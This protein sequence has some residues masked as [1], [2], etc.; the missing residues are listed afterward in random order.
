MLSQ[1]QWQFLQYV[2]EK[3]NNQQ[4]K[5]WKRFLKQLLSQK[6]NTEMDF[7][8]KN[9]EFTIA[10]DRACARIEQEE[11]YALWC[12]KMQNQ[13]NRCMSIEKEEVLNQIE[14]Q[15][16]AGRM[17]D[18][19]DT[20]AYRKETAENTSTESSANG[21]EEISK[22]PIEVKE[23]ILDR[24]E[25][26]TA[27][28]SIDNRHMLAHWIITTLKN[29]LRIEKNI[30]SSKWA[31]RVLPAAEGIG[32]VNLIKNIAKNTTYL[33][34]GEIIVSADNKKI[35]NGIASKRLREIQHDQE[36]GATIEGIKDVI[37]RAKIDTSLEYSNDKS[38][39]NKN[40]Q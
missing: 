4:K 39:S 12:K 9:L 20:V 7:A 28:A 27:D 33:N 2:N 6:I 36:V 8:P 31:N 14:S 22:Y 37:K 40:F 11:N 30:S 24:R 13:N 1:L 23:V 34:S 32:I 25:I 29:K 35:I 26:A 38:R 17:S 15:G 3:V 5:I 21:N 19:C 16:F 10:Q 18:T